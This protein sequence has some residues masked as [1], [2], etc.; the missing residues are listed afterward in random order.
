MVSFIIVLL[1]VLSEFLCA[2]C[3]KF[4]EVPVPK[5]ELVK[6]TVFSSDATAIAAQTDIFI[7]MGSGEGFSS[8]LT[9]DLALAADEFKNYNSSADYIQLYQNSLS[10]SNNNILNKWRTFYKYIYEANSVLEGLEKSNGVTKKIKDQLTGE[11]K[12]TRAY[13]YF[14]LVNLFGDVPLIT[15][16][17]YHE[18]S[19]ASRT[20]RT[21]VYQQ[22]LSD[23]A[24]AS[25]LLNDDFLGPDLITVST[26]RVRPTKSAAAAMLAR[27][28]LYLIDW[29]NAE[30]QASLVIG[31]SKFAITNNLDSVFLKNSNEAILQLASP[32]NSNTRE[33]GDFILTSTPWSVSMSSQLLNSFEIND[34]RKMKWVDSITV[35]SQTYYYPF[36]YKINYSTT[37][38]EYTMVLRVTEQYLIRAEARAQQNKVTEAL[39]DLNLIRNKRGLPSS[40]AS[41]KTSI[42]TAIENERQ[43]ELFAEWGHRWLDLKRTNRVDAIM[44]GVTPQKGNAWN[45]NQQWFPIPQAERNIDPNLSQNP[46]F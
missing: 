19:L 7:K 23:L 14:Y 16:T 11:A 1:I 2:G 5:T 18:N 9:S 34:N 38:T 26:E 41:D 29:A 13:L 24:D 6:E 12:F 44:S 20:E 31:S 30:T 39:A 36:K 8:S 10:A 22:I 35:G 42:L 43:V 37:V 28:Y 33:G 27:V 21:K 32:P 45:S 40:M 3:K 25:S 15:T 46:G 4:V 17:D